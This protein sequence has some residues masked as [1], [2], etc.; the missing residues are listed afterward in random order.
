MRDQVQK[1]ALEAWKETHEGVV[2]L[3]TGFGKTRLGV[4]AIAEEAPHSKVLVVTSRKNLI[5]Q[6]EE[7]CK[8]MGVVPPRILCINSAYKLEEEVDLLI[9]D[10]CHRSFSPEFGKLYENI[11]AKKKLLLTASPVEM[12]FKTVYR[13]SMDDAVEMGAVS[14]YKMFNVG[15][16]MDRVT[17]SK[18]KTFDTMFLSGAVFL[19]KIAAAMGISPF[20]LAK[21]NSG[22]T[23]K[24][25]LIRASKNFWNGMTMRKWAVYSNANKKIVAKNL[26]LADKNSKWIVFWK[27]IK[28]AENFKDL[29]SPHV[30]CLVYHS[31][32]KSRERE[33]IL[34]K[35]ASPIYK[36][37]ISVEAL[38]EGLNIVEL[39][40]AISAAGV[41]TE[42]VGIQT[43]GRIC[44]KKEGKTA[45]FINLYSNNTVEKRWVQERT[46]SLKA[47]EVSVK[48]IT[49]LLRSL[50]PLQPT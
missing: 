49:G 15:V 23:E 40:R 45:I 38:N 28:D 46:K 1:E 34:L 19:S 36:V 35:F 24:S 33:E 32:L 2:V 26:I 9:V 13:K 44:R 21:Q 48:E 29:V 10:E 3:P 4:M 14:D 37:L 17:A 47:L 22:K 12:P 5:T 31:K 18:Y 20:E 25:E 11:K 39:D 6:W 42:L 43:L 30:P 8:N 50:K 41:A 7:E 27:S 16:D